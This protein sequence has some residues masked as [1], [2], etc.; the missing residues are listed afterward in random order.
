MVFKEDEFKQ[1]FLQKFTDAGDSD[2]LLYTQ[3]GR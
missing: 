2:Y 1:A 3:G